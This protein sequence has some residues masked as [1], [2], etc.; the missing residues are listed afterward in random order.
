LT[1]SEYT[2]WI[3][4]RATAV[5]TPASYAQPDTFKVQASDR[6]WFIPDE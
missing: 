2:N 1:D 6:V 3:K 4:A 5:A